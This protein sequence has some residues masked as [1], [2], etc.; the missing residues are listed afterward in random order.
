MDKIFTLAVVGPTASGKTE[1]AVRLAQKFDGEIVSADSMQ[2][3]KGMDIA[4]AM[5]TSQERQRAVHHLIDFVSPDTPFSVAKYTDLA[6]KC[7]RDI[8]NRGK[9]P[10]VC[11]GTGMYI[12]SLFEN[13][14]YLSD[15]YDEALREKLNRL[16]DEIGGEKMLCM[17]S[18]KDEKT[19]C[20]LHPN[21]KKR[22]VRAFE[23]IELTGQTKTRQNELSKIN[24][25]EFDVFYIGLTASDRQYLY[26]R[27][28][29]RVD[30]MLENGLENEARQFFSCS[31]KA[32][33]VQ[34]IG[35]KEL[36]PYIDGLCTYEEAVQTLKMQ[37]RR[38][39]KRQLT[40]F[41][42]NEN[43][44]WFETDKMTFDEIEESVCAIIEKKR[45]E[46]Q[47]NEQ[48]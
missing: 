11:G 27:I 21:D 28:N 5:P 22:I 17:L 32:T 38:Y 19:A 25:P 9:L 10:V 37:T 35:Y 33:A 48:K 40:W 47:N 1:L 46:M 2:I 8:H 15:G 45:K 41:R 20:A 23:L 24:P 44:I 7:I 31:D 14:T 26:D 42:R 39:A 6:G 43:I 13:I 34:A 30:I 16:Y 4:V 18:E 29:K 36:K 3:Y 12:N